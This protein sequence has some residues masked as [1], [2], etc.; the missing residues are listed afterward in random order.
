ME[1][2]VDLDFEAFVEQAVR[3]GPEDVAAQLRTGLRKRYDAP[4]L[5][6]MGRCLGRNVP[7]QK[8]RQ[9]LFH[10]SG[11]DMRLYP[12]LIAM[13]PPGAPDSHPQLRVQ[14]CAL[15][16]LYLV[17]STSWALVQ[18]FIE[19]GGLRQLAAALAHPNPYLAGQVLSTL[20]HVTDEDQLFAWHDPPAAADGRE[21]R[22]GPYALVWRRMCELSG[23]RFLPDLL[24]HYRHPPVFPGASGMALRL[25]AFYL[26]W[27]RRHFTTDGRLSLSSGLLDLLEGWGRDAQVTEDERQL[28]KQLHQ[29]FSRGCWRDRPLASGPTRCL[30]SMQVSVVSERSDINHGP[31][32]DN[33]AEL[34]REAGNT[35][36]RRGDLNAAV[37]LYSSALDLP[38]PTERLLSEA[39]RRAGLHANRAAAYMARAEQSLREGDVDSSGLLEGADHG[40]PH[41]AARQLEAAVI[42]CDAALG[43]QH[44]GAAAAKT[45]LRKCR[46]LLRLGRAQQAEAAARQGLGAADGG[47]GATEEALHVELQE[48]LRTQQRQTQQEGEMA[49]RKGDSVEGRDA[50]GAAAGSGSVNWGEMD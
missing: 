33:E 8:A 45:C 26:S 20:L 44:S 10:P 13:P 30:L 12:H 1:Q 50:G 29:D 14:V 42:D 38:V 31:S 43:L 6:E 25:L 37:H 39:P 22:A 7:L 19:A 40:S 23:T 27:M 24:A 3:D 47:G 41:A 9:L 35:A 16:S 36:Y 2:E 32:A 18:P 28:A 4:P 21:P 49:G 34:L 46:A 11:D 17:H 5:E 15:A 48:A